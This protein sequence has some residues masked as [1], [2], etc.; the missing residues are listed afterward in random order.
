[1]SDLPVIPV[2]T[3]MTPSQINKVKEF[4][5]N[6][7]PGIADIKDSALS[8]MLDLY[9]NG[10]SY[11]Q[12]SNTLKIKQVYVLYFAY[13][14]NWEQ[15]RQEYVVELQE[16][17]K[18]RIVNSKLKNKEFILLL[19]QVYQKKLG[20]KLIKFLSSENDADL[21]E[22]Q[23]KEVLML[24]KMMEMV[25]SLDNEGK[26]KDGKAAVGLNLG[27]N[28]VL[29]EKTGDNQLSITPK[30]DPTVGNLLKQLADERRSRESTTITVSET[31][32]ESNN[33]SE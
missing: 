18:S 5:A 31:K 9:L 22:V 12:I 6:G 17:L 33:D 14:A 16:G 29:V 1:M 25:D 21:T 11:S 20:A 24:M 2:I 7:L 23:G 28:G 13:T 10:S 26:A 32:K 19:T 3:D 27:A 30:P 4:I 8:Q 15:L